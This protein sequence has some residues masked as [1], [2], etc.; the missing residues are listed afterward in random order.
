LIAIAKR[1]GYPL[2]EMQPVIGRDI[3]VL[4]R[5]STNA[6]TNKGRQILKRRESNPNAREGGGF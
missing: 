3:S 1:T 2:T 6:E 4:S 5:M